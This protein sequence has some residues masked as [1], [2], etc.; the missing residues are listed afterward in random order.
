[1]PQHP[2]SAIHLPPEAVGEQALGFESATFS[3]VDEQA[4]ALTGW[5]Q[6][7][8]QLSGGGFRGAIQR[9]D[10]GPVRLFKEGL[11][12]TVY[13]NGQLPSGVLAL[14]IPLH[15]DGSSVFCGALSDRNALHMF[16]G[17]SGFEFRTGSDHVMMGLELDPM[18]ANTLYPWGHSALARN[19]AGLRATDQ[20]ALDGLRQVMLMLF[21][22]AHT[23][24]A[25]FSLPAV[26]AGMVDTLVEKVTALNLA[27]C[28]S[29]AAH[30][31]H[32]QLVQQTRALV[33][34][35]LR[36]APTV[37][38]LCVELGVSRRTLQ[39]AFH[40]ILGI[41]PLAYLRAIRLG[42][43]RQA[44]KTASSV[45]EAATDM[46]FWHFGHF[47]KDYQAMFG[48]LPS[49]THKRSLPPLQ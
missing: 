12:S 16:S 14:G 8:L 47:A 40:R 5:N 19:E 46:G 42:A 11:G 21:E 43:V 18:L 6:S 26:R 36:Q 45:T 1:M 30:D 17:Q 35:Q 37:G 34:N 41:S 38:E 24:P 29:D 20:L 49:Q 22:T 15:C 3:D 48:E 27:T 7:Y 39:N 2:I 10:L 23:A 32:W 33:Q 25:M 4:A 44:L 13:Q 31:G 28:S 9:V